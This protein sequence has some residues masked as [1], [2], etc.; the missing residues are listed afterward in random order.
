MDN[1]NL[2]FNLNAKNYQPKFNPNQY[3]NQQTDLTQQNFSN[4]YYQQQQQQ[5]Q[6]YAQNYYQ[7]NKNY[8]SKI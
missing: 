8:Q 2:N 6:N 1:Q 5:P 4:S 3:Y 7:Q